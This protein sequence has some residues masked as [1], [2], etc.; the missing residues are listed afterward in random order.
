MSEQRALNL[1]VVAC[2]V[3]CTVPTVLSLIERWRA[4]HPV[5]VPLHA[6]GTLH[7]LPSVWLREIYDDVR[8][9]G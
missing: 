1:L 5:T 4:A 6:V 9:P 3:V 8:P 7:P 2:T